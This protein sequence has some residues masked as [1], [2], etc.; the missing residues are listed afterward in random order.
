MAAGPANSGVHRFGAYEFEPRVGELRKQG[1]RIRLEGQPIAILTLLLNRPGELVTREELQKKLWPADTFVDFEQ[2]LNAAIKRLRAALGDNADNP[3]FIET[4]P[5][6]GYRFIVS[7]EAVSVAATRPSRTDV[8]SSGRQ[9]IAID[10]RAVLPLENAS[11]GALDEVLAGAPE[12][13]SGVTA[14]SVPF[15]QR[16]LPWAVTTCLTIAVALGLV[17]VHFREKPHASAAPVQRYEFAAPDP[18]VTAVGALSPDGTR[19]VLRSSVGTGPR[20]WL[21]RMDS[22]EAHPLEGSEGANAAPFWSHDSRLIVFG[23]EDGKVKK[24]DTEG[25]PAQVLCDSGN[26]VVGGFWTLDS[27]IVFADPSRSG[28]WK[29][30]AAGGACS[31][32][33]GFEHAGNPLVYFPVLL[34]DGKHFLY[35][36]GSLASGDVYLGLLDSKLGH[37]SSKKLLSALAAAYAPSPNDP[38]LGYLVL[39]RRVPNTNTYTVLAQPFDLQKLEVVG[40]PVPIAHQVSS[41]SLSLN[42]T[43]VYVSGATAI[44]TSQLT[45][46]DRAGQILGTVGE[47]A[48][49]ESVAFSPDGKRVIAAQSSQSGSEN[50]WMMDL[51]RGISTRFTFDSGFDDRPVWSPDGSRVAFQSNRSD[52]LDLYQKLSNGGGEDELLLKPN[53]PVMPLSW[54]G[55]GRFLLFGGGTTA[56][57]VNISVLPMDANGHA[58]GKPFPFAEKGVGIEERFSPGPQGRPLWVAY[59][60]DESGR[61]EIYVRPFD[62]NSPTGTPP[63]GGKWQVSTGGGLTPRWNSNGKE[64]FYVALDGT[65]MSVEVRGGTVFQ[66][67]TPKP[68]FKP[69]GFSPQAIY[70]DWDV[71]SDGKKFI[72]PVLSLTAGIAP[73]PRFT[74][75]LNWP[76]L[77]KK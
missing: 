72:F 63:G 25:G 48:A 2:S 8:P 16:A 62:P 60:S 51:V 4:L 74:V 40:E 69:K 33:P 38:T 29:V 57:D 23:T 50:L 47:P 61:F 32:L 10:S 31:P 73:P 68:M 37:Q 28:L 17:F 7:V 76:S 39:A 66:S 45:L 43:L 6:R 5:R 53:D 13:A 12:P 15:W 49:Y 20:L 34:P 67:G 3:H 58:A 64:L 56:S 41:V 11:D 75:V 30:P 59:S 71:T 44:G 21:R 55:D 54:S 22:L 36:S 42:G 27:K 19:L 26:A 9:P 46:F 24:I 70:A 77:L 65:V 52:H 18:S 1:M 14:T 35:T